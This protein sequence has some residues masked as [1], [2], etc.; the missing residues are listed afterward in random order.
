M[1]F[2]GFLVLVFYVPP[3]RTFF[4]QCRREA[5]LGTFSPCNLSRLRPRPLGLP[6]SRTPPPPLPPLR[7]P[8]RPPARAARGPSHTPPP[9][10]P[11]QLLR[12]THRRPPGPPGRVLRGGRGGPPWTIAM[13]TGSTPL[14]PHSSPLRHSGGGFNSAARHVLIA[15][16]LHHRDLHLPDPQL[17]APQAAVPTPEAW[18][19]MAP[20][21]IEA[22]L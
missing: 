6:G 20:E 18:A 17:P 11:P 1:L 8:Q 10:Q 12:A 4:W 15:L 5:V 13:A 19:E 16:Y 21:E 22:Y 7:G 2:T 14:P 9:C 3:K